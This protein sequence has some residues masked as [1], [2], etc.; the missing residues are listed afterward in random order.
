MR[1]RHRLCVFNFRRSRWSIVFER[2]QDIAASIVLMEK[3]GSKRRSWRFRSDLKGKRGVRITVECGSGGMRE[4]RHLG[5]TRIL[6]RI[7]RR[8]RAIIAHVGAR[9]RTRLPQ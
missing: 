3:D 6:H 4:I 5:G 2:E 8:L 7:P 1:I 9:R